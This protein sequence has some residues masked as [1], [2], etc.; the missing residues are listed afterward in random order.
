MYPTKSTVSLKPTLCRQV[1][2]MALRSQKAT[3]RSNVVKLAEHRRHGEAILQ[4]LAS[5]SHSDKHE[6]DEETGKDS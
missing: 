4:R 1:A 2:T 5:K 3:P 6:S